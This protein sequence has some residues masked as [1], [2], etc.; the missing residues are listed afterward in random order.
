MIDSRKKTKRKGTGLPRPRK[1]LPALPA[2]TEEIQDRLPKLQYNAS[3]LKDLHTR[4]R[5]QHRAQAWF[6]HLSLL[7]RALRSLL[8]IE[9]A[10]LELNHPQ[11]LQIGGYYP[12]AAS[13]GTSAEQVRKRFD[14]ETEM[15]ARKETLEEWIRD[16]LVPECYVRLSVLVA[17]GEGSFAG[18]G[19]VLVGIVAVVGA[20][21]GLPT[22]AEE[23]GMEGL[24]GGVEGSAHRERMVRRTDE[25][26][27]RRAER[28]REEEADVEM[29]SE[30]NDFG[31]VVERSKVPKRRHKSESE[32]APSAH[33]E[34]G[35]LPERVL[36]ASTRILEQEK[37]SQETPINEPSKPPKTTPRKRA[38]SPSK[39]KDEKK[40]KKKNA[41]D[42]LFAGFD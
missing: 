5:N 39:R 40:P 41:I 19:V 25:V 11:P 36:A 1:P 30:A 9:T 2:S 14:R 6:K 12:S 20:L 29:D 38:L 10:L 32:E 37:Q 34:S 31:T 26:M 42:D 16:V 24:R 27:E 33:A 8:T 21:I 18:L 15:K 35:N 13:T 4:H 28:A 22:Y 23:S 7:L 3:L 17:D